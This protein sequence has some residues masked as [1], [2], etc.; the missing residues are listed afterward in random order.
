M[1]SIGFEVH[2]DGS[3][4][5]PDLSQVFSLE[6]L[7][8]FK[9]KE[10]DPEG[11]SPD[12]RLAR[13]ACELSS[14]TS[15]TRAAIKNIW[16][17]YDASHKG[18]FCFDQ[19]GIF[20]DLDPNANLNWLEIKQII[21]QFYAASAQPMVNSTSIA[22]ACL[23]NSKVIV[24]GAMPWREPQV[25]RVVEEA[26][27]FFQAS[28]ASFPRHGTLLE[29][30]RET[31]EPEDPPHMLHSFNVD[32]ALCGS[33]LELSWL[34]KGSERSHRKFL[35]LL[36]NENLCTADKATDLARF[37]MLVAPVDCTAPWPDEWIAS[38]LRAPEEHF[39]ALAGNVYH[40]KLGL[41]PDQAPKVKAYIGFEHGLFSSSALLACA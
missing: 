14:L 19:P 36:V 39:S 41:A 25:V 20:C 4:A 28:V 32:A 5:L 17:E 1:G 12:G 11:A 21:D 16:L 23:G 10:P 33:G 30:L 29:K 40:Y 2:L 26:P 24:A 31:I 6:Q 13:L 3:P 38:S 9:F 37:S 22:N 7:E 35:N 27:D 8:L 34:K 15:S 18:T